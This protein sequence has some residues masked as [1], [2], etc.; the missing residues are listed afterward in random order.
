MLQK[1]VQRRSKQIKEEKRAKVL[2]PTSVGGDAV[3]PDLGNASQAR[4]GILQSD[5]FALPLSPLSGLSGASRTPER[6]I[7]ASHK[8]LKRSLLQPVRLF[9]R[10][11]ICQHF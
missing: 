2:L 3:H 5:A 8:G 6:V 1:Y 7:K 11:V 9:R 10:A 4:H